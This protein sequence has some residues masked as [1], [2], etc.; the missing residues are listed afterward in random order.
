MDLSPAFAEIVGELAR[1][2]F[3]PTDGLVLRENGEDVAAAKQ[4]AQ[5]VM[6]HP[7]VAACLPEK[8]RALAAS[9]K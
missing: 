8:A 5:K 4:A 7:Q 6:L 2:I 3:P 9:L 1:D